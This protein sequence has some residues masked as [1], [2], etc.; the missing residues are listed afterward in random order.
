MYTLTV[1]DGKTKYVVSFEGSPT[2][3]QVLEANGITMPHPCGGSG[4]CGKCT[5]E[6][7]G[8][9]SL[10]DQKELAQGSRLSC[11]TR[12]YGNAIVTLCSDTNLT[13]ESSAE[14][15]TP[16]ENPAEK[17]GIASD[18]GTTTIALSVYDLTT[19][20]CL[21]TETMLNPQSCIAADVVG[22]IEAA[23]NG[24]LSALQT[25]VVTCLKTLAENSGYSGR[26]DKWCLTGNTTML[27]LLCGRDPKNLAVSPFVAEHLFGEE[28][29][30]LETKAYLPNCMNA[31]IGADITCAVLSGGLCDTDETALLCDLG[32]NGEIVLWKN[33]KLY[34]TSTAAGPV[35][36]GAGISCGCQS[37]R[38]AIESVSLQNGKLSL[39]T[40][41]S[42]K[43]VGLCGSG[44]IDAVACFL[45]NGTIDETGAMETEEFFL[46]D[47]ISLNR[48]DIRNVQLAKAAIAAGIRTLLE[49]TRTPEEELSAFYI[50]GGF[51][52]HLNLASAVRIGLFPA[53]LQSKVKVLGNAALKGA[54]AMLTSEELKNKAA[55]IASDATCIN[56]GGNSEFNKYYIEEMFF[57]K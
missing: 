30:F 40:I 31:F 21:A 5:I 23:T 8:E 6:I 32:T 42:Q 46:C 3:Q 52:T 43:A 57:P 51:G 41:G 22:R 44:V 18:I 24:K 45:D 2:V 10:P 47:G 15:I 11:R 20:T 35:F 48:Q 19:G 28:L 17:I 25:M 37:I 4:R 29:A 50:A 34:A 1:L 36:E 14:R 49:L 54:A 12:L 38:G 55:V 7:I 39:K 16:S 26:V 27:Y 56:L 9:T 33:K 53:S 13:A